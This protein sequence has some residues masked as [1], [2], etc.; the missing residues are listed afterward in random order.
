[1]DLVCQGNCSA[2]YAAQ[3]RE[4]DFLLSFD[5]CECCAHGVLARH[6]KGLVVN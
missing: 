1:M 2:K 6:L 4:K 3:W 5:A